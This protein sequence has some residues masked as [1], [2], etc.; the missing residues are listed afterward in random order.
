MIDATSLDQAMPSWLS[1]LDVPEYSGLFT[2]G[3]D[4]SIYLPRLRPCLKWRDLTIEE[5]LD[6]LVMLCSSV[7]YVRDPQVSYVSPQLSTGQS[8]YI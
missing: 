1:L 5:L 2:I 8:A 6:F 3:P 7:A 4:G